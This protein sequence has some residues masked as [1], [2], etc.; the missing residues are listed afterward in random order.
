MILTLFITVPQTDGNLVFSC[1]DSKRKLFEDECK[2]SKPEQ[3]YPWMVGPRSPSSPISFMISR[4]KTSFRLARMIRGISLSWTGLKVKV[5][6]LLK[7]PSIVYPFHGVATLIPHAAL[8]MIVLYRARFHDA[9]TIPIKSNF[10]LNYNW[11]WNWVTFNQ[12]KMTQ[13]HYDFYSITVL[14]AYH[15][16]FAFLLKKG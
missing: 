7:L 10:D 2:A 5:Y 6:F 1:Q 13:V 12:Y 14:N 16:I 3:P 15:S 4:W 9:L 8:L 11:I